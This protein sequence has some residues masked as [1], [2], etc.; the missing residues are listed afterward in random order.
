MAPALRLRDA[1]NENGDRQRGASPPVVARAP[2]ARAW[3][4]KEILG[5]FN[6]GWTR[7]NADG[8]LDAFPFLVLHS[9]VLPFS[10][11]PTLHSL[12]FVSFVV[13]CSPS[14]RC[15]VVVCF[16]HEHEY[17]HEQEYEAPP[18]P[19]APMLPSGFKKI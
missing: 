15:V 17:E 19:R 10:R 13:Q 1:P 8:R 14:C 2:C 18:R 6:H 4:E 3:C 7:I 11:S 5:K 9:P 16:E 12:Y